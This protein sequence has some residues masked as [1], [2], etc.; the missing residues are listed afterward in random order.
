MGLDA[1]RSSWLVA[2]TL[3]AGAGLAA[4]GED[5]V[6]DL[7]ILKSGQTVEVDIPVNERRVNYDEKT[8]YT[9]TR[10]D[11]SKGAYKGGDIQEVKFRWVRQ[12]EA[13][14]GY[15]KTGQ[16]NDEAKRL[17]SAIFHFL[18]T[19][20]DEEQAALG[21]RYEKCMV[22]LRIVG[23]K[24]LPPAEA[25]D[26]L[27]EL[28][29][30]YPKQ[31]GVGREVATLV[32][33]QVEAARR[34]SDWSAA[35]RWVAELEKRYPQSPELKLLRVQLQ[36]DAKNLKSQAQAE[37]Q[38]GQV[39]QAQERLRDAVR[40][41]P[42]DQ[43]L[44]NALREMQKQTPVLSCGLLGSFA[45]VDPLSRRSY[46]DR[47]L[48]ELCFRSLFTMAGNATDGEP[49]Q[50][51][52]DLTETWQV[53]D[54]GT[55]VEVRLRPGLTWSDGK[56]LTATDVNYT[57][58]VL[59]DP[60]NAGYQPTLSK[61]LDPDLAVYAPEQ[62]AVRFRMPSTCPLALLCF[63]ILPAHAGR[64]GLDREPALPRVVS[65]AFVPGRPTDDGFILERNDRYVG[66]RPAIARI[67]VHLFTE[68]EAGAGLLR[69]GRIQ[70]LAG[71]PAAAAAQ[72]Q[73]AGQLGRTRAVSLYYVALNEGHFAPEAKE[74][75]PAL[76][77]ALASAID[78]KTLLPVAGDAAAEGLFP[79]GAWARHP[80]AQVALPEYDPDSARKQIAKV[81]RLAARTW[82]CVYPQAGLL[83]GAGPRVARE[84]RAA[85]LNVQEKALAPGVF[86]NQVYEKREFDIALAAHV[87]V[88]DTYD[89]A[90][91][92]ELDGRDN[93]APVRDPDLLELLAAGRNTIDRRKSRDLANA[94]EKLV[95]TKMYLIPLCHTDESFV[96]SPRLRGVSSSP[97]FVFDHVA[98]WSLVPETP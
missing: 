62:F 90:D 16:Y 49:T 76:R 97:R 94:L 80:E 61:M 84:L 18:P 47:T 23:I 67:V 78:R 1:R 79:R 54:D 45:R 15:C 66:P 71:L 31:A 13:L 46:V 30:E 82:C 40:L 32:F 28:G 81:D 10:A 50:W 37:S 7:L 98:G 59:S 38:A 12:I 35:H 65:G 4:R 17:S 42:D 43:D 27:D 20:P 72:L 29:R 93:L 96:F 14:E 75:W 91:L 6:Y 74:Q 5:W 51:A 92:F 87:F 25:L 68:Y 83:G 52:G 2:M 3:L 95:V 88:D 21:D 53:S 64:G 70:L 19:L 41:F 55:L 85:G 24:P 39:E 33:G 34:R 86:L 36:R 9:F 60:K 58:A 69:A 44:R 22:C 48:G 11:G 26:A 77:I 57:L 56:P 63:P 89:V 73:D 8:F